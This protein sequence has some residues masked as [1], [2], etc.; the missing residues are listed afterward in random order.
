MTRGVDNFVYT[1]WIFE[2]L[3]KIIFP[4]ICPLS[5]VANFFSVFIIFLLVLLTVSFVWRSF[6]HNLM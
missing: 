4:K 2:F 6:S 1:Y 5:Y 3:S